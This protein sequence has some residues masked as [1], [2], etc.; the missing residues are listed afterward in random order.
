VSALFGRDAETGE[1]AAL[2]GQ[3]A[4]AGQA[5]VMIGEPGIGKT[6]LL[7]AA[8]GLARDSGFQVLTATGVESEAQFPFAGL[9]QLL[10][11]VL[12]ARGAVALLMV[13]AAVATA[14]GLEAILGAFLAGAAIKLL[15]RDRAMT[16]GLFRVKLRAVGFGAF[17]PFFFV[18]TG[19]ALDL[20][21]LA[22][23]GTLAR[24]PIF[25]AVLLVVRAVPALLYRP[26]AARRA[27]LVAAGLLQATSLSIPIVAGAIGVDLG[28]IRPGNYATLVAAGLLSVIAFPL[29]ALPRLAGDAKRP[30]AGAGE[31]IGSRTA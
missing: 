16:H 30:S 12:G 22:S 3:A 5:I 28:L 15:D 9:H 10:R 14:F 2:I 24:V 18:S 31:G 6:A 23:P 8:A 19:M 4:R 21:S 20:H 11:P 29:L 7:G 17:V 1:L 26:L 25:L 13:F 27:Q